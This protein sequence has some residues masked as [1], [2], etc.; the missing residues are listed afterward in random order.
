M[1]ADVTANG[2]IAVIEGVET[3][4]GTTVAA[5]DL[6]A[7]AAMIIAGLIA[8][9]TTVI[10]NV[11]HIDRGYVDVVAKFRSLGA[12]IWRVEE[13]DTSVIETEAV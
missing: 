7:G 3:L 9:G 12:N 11:D 5:D 2:S 1:G 10:E 8:N 6:R 13:D 4:T